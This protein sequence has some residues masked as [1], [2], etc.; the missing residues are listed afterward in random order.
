M[1][2]FFRKSA[3]LVAGLGLAAG[4]AVCGATPAT[5]EQVDYSCDSHEVCFY[6]GGNFWGSVLTFYDDNPDHSQYHFGGY[7]EGRTEGLEDNAASVKNRATSSYVYIYENRNY[8]GAVMSIQPGTWVG[9]MTYLRNK[10][11]SHR[12]STS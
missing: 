2:T 5:A 9:D 4:A 3:T 8:G 12:F 6:W 10:N 1:G 11:S 7:Q